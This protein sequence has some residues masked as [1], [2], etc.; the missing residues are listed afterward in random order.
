MQLEGLG[1]RMPV[2]PVQF[3]L[4]ITIAQTSGA[5]T[6]GTDGSEVRMQLPDRLQLGLYL[7]DGHLELGRVIL[8]NSDSTSTTSASKG[9]V[10][11][12]Y[13]HLLQFS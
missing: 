12:S 1:S 13:T 10:Y 9:L 2:P 11:L 4:F 5:R 7:R 3:R 8:Y 6:W